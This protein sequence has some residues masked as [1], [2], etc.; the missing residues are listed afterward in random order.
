MAKASLPRANERKKLFWKMEDTLVTSSKVFSFLRDLM[1]EYIS[2]DDISKL[3]PRPKI[4]QLEISCDK[5]EYLNKK[6]Q[7]SKILPYQKQELITKITGGICSIC[8]DTPTKI[9][10]YD[11]SGIILIERYC[12]KCIETIKIN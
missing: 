2:N 3:K 7:D 12:D 11:M 8:K 6:L 4:T 10:S 5:L 1:T 9:A